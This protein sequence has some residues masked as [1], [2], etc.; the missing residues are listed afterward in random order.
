MQSATPAA[1]SEIDLAGFFAIVRERDPLTFP[2]V[3]EALPNPLR[4]AGDWRLVMADQPRVVLWDGLSESAAVLLTRLFD[5]QRLSL[6]PCHPALYELAE[7]QLD[8]APVSSL[9]GV[10]RHECWLT[11]TISR[12][13][14][15]CLNSTQRIGYQAAEPSN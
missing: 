12:G 14:I 6:Q 1:E 11:C 8:L 3:I 2:E 7:R 5:L 13:P 10:A 15:P 4:E 9:P